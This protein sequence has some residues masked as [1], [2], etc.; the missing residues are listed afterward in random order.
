M[1]K[2][3]IGNLFYDKDMRSLYFVFMSCL[4]VTFITL[5]LKH[6]VTENVPS[7][8]YSFEVGLKETCSN[9]LGHCNSMNKQLAIIK[10]CTATAKIIHNE[11]KLKFLYLHRNKVNKIKNKLF[12]IVYIY[13]VHIN[14]KIIWDRKQIDNIG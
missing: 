2:G 1:Q 14:Y 5:K 8:N 12:N 3:E 4:S 7:G 9:T 13:F 10:I 11:Y 6:Q